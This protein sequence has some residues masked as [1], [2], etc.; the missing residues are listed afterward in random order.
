MIGAFL[1]CITG[2]GRSHFSSSRLPLP[3]SVSF[4]LAL[5]YN[6]LNLAARFSVGTAGMEQWI[7]RCAVSIAVLSV[8]YGM[9][10]MPAGSGGH[11]QEKSRAAKKRSGI[12]IEGRICVRVGVDRADVLVI[13]QIDFTS[14]GDMDLDM[15]HAIER[16][17]QGDRGVAR[18]LA[19]VIVIRESAYPP[20]S[21][22]Q[23]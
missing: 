8:G 2:N 23:G 18:D 15:I 3:L 16:A 9:Q 6:L 11:S 21:R 10:N 20:P 7:I 5:P 12:E 17:G 13:D 22:L 4:A 14:H 19:G 1:P